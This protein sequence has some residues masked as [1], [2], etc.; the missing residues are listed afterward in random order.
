MSALD[1]VRD[2]IVGTARAQGFELAP[3]FELNQNRLRVFSDGLQRILSRLPLI[4]GDSDRARAEIAHSQL[5]GAIERLRPAEEVAWFDRNRAL[6]LSIG[7][8][9]SGQQRELAGIEFSARESPPTAGPLPLESYELRSEAE[10]TA[11]NIE[12]VQI[13]TT[14]QTLD[15]ADRA[16]LR[17]YTGWG[18]LSIK[19]AA[20]ALPPGWVPEKKALI[21]E[22]YTPELVANAIAQTL[23][24]YQAELTNA[25]GVIRVLEPSAGIGRLVNAFSPSA[26]PQI[27]WTAIELSKV[28]ASLLAAA[29]P[30]ITVVNSPLE[31]WVVENK[32]QFGTYDLVVSNPPY[33]VRGRYGSVDREKGYAETRAYA[34]QIRRGIDMLR[35]NG[36]GVFLIPSGFVSGTGPSLRALRERVLLRSHFMGAF[37]LPSE[38]DEGKS[39]FPGALLVTDVVFLRSRGGSIAAV[40]DADQYILEGRYFAVTPEH[41]LGREV[42]REGDDD[43]Q[44]R[45]PRWGYQVR[46]TFQGLPALEER[47]QCRDCTVTPQRRPEKRK[48]VELPEHAEHALALARRAAA[49]LELIARGDSEA[50]ARAAAAHPELHQDLSAWFA[51]SPEQRRED[52]KFAKSEPDMATLNNIFA[53]GKLIAELASPPKYEER[54]PGSI[55]DL[56]TLAHWLWRRSRSLSIDDL[57]QKQQAMGGTVT[58]EEALTALRNAGWCED[59]GGTSPLLPK[60]QYYAGSLWP[61][62]D[63]ARERAE[64]GDAVAAI[65]ASQLLATIKPATFAEINVEPR[66][67]W[68]PQNVVEAWVNDV[69]RARGNYALE[70][71]GAFLTLAGVKYLDL[72]NQSDA[73]RLVLGYL[74]H[75]MAYFK[76]SVSRDENIEEKRTAYAAQLKEHFINWIEKHPEHQAAVAETHNRIFRGWVTPEYSPDPVIIARWNPEYPLWPYQNAAVRRMVENRGGGCFFDVGLGKTR[77]LLG[78]VALAKQQG[79]ARRVVIAAPNSLVFNWAREIERVLP[80]FRYA[81]IGAR[82]KIISRGPKKG[83]LVSEPD[84]PEMRAA[85]WQRFQAGLYDIVIV[86]YSALPRTQLDL[87]EILEVVRSVPAVQRELVLKVRETEKRIESLERKEKAGKLDEEQEEELRKLRKQLKGMAGTE[88]KEAIL[89]EREEGFAAKWAV[90]PV[91]QEPDPG[92]FWSKLGID[93][94]GY[95]ESHVGKNL[96]TAGTREGGEPRFLGSPQEGS[97][98]AWQLYLRSFLVRKSTGGTGVYLADATPAKNSPLEF[99]SILSLID[100]DIWSRLGIVDPEQYITQYLN[101][102]TRLIQDTDLEPAEVPC[103][104]GFKNLDQ[105]REVL[106]RYGEF[107]TA[108][109]VGLKIPEPRVHRIEVEMDADQEA[110]YTAYLEAYQSALENL[111]IN[112]EG[113]F[114]ALGLLQR[115]ALVAVHSLLDEGPPAAQGSLPLDETAGAVVAPQIVNLDDLPLTDPLMPDEE[116]PRRSRLILLSGV[117]VEKVNE[118]TEA[119]LEAAYREALRTTEPELVSLWREDTASQYAHAKVKLAAALEKRQRRAG[120][121]QDG[122]RRKDKPKWTYG[123]ARLA[124]KF[125]SPKLSKIVEVIVNRKDCGHIVF[126]ENVAAHYWLKQLLVKAGID[127]ARIAVLNGETAPDP[128]SRQRIAEGFTTAEPPLYDIVIANRIAYEGVN[129]Q[130]RTCSIFHGDLPYEPAT[131]QQR[132]GR[133]QRQGNRYD[134]IDIYYILSKRS[135]DM[136]RFQLIAGKRE[137]MAAIIESAASETNNPAA[138]ADLSPEDWLIYL[139]RDEAKT[140]ALIERKKQEAQQAEN[141]RVIKLA[142]ASIRQIAIR[143]R[144][145]AN[146]TDPIAK[147]HLLDEIASISADVA[148]TDPLIWPWRFVAVEASRH[149]TLSFAPAHDG[150]VWET[151]CLVRAR[152]DG[153]QYGGGEFG[154]VTYHPNSIGYRRFRELEW[155]SLNAD[156]AF[157]IWNATNPKEWQETPQPMEAELGPAVEQLIQTIQRSGIFSYKELRLSLASERFRLDFWHKW[158]LDLVRALLSSYDAERARIPAK[159]GQPVAATLALLNKQD[160]SIYPFTTEGYTAFLAD[161]RAAG[162]LRWGEIDS[163]TDWWWGKRAPRNVL[164]ADD[165]GIGEDDGQIDS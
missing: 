10:R 31:Q 107:R 3:W 70:R 116:F 14:K 4:N 81:I 90:P 41:V 113:K 149:P 32:H 101:I 165:K 42:G 74:N 79:L 120:S 148:Q 135:S 27:K 61:K 103:V 75:D 115:M 12:A 158:G 44:G 159:D 108:K 9:I 76:P 57:V 49:Y 127:E 48:R 109:Q 85:K 28:S 123:N 40:P 106:F 98:I 138:Q 88:R 155:E 22:Y 55:D 34:Y 121:A 82:A 24:P 46:G 147:A 1:V 142:W 104:V 156:A 128:A 5:R 89:E 56:P 97:Y 69:T 18:G 16:K 117:P 23:L 37:R 119:E 162:N 66:L 21:H 86:T 118:M 36:I 124:S 62:Y 58:T 6:L 13:L 47:D 157:A 146:A 132:N 160:A 122:K 15:D 145:A 161:C 143:Q 99:L 93:F 126:L 139:S 153:T 60:D 134:V 129:L 94:L 102:Q 52:L 137:W 154:A 73:I 114:A 38:T 67:G 7:T 20:S 30:D 63:R 35:P 152:P 130:T 43:E 140:K 87:P 92:I 105:L 8:A 77:T 45:A 11:A 136:A 29:R 141:Q 2:Q 25:E 50:M 95:D 72:A 84:T 112:P 144:D 100:S 133:G 68:L 151:A 80:D 163:M 83:E 64:A 125:D 53:G 110:K 39:L 96:W 71:E 17:R 51:Q 164:A 150:A 33:G 65:Q 111:S 91:G 19:R 54:Y 26:W 131:L 59:P 78:A